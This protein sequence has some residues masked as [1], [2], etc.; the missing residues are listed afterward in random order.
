MNNFYQFDLKT[1]DNAPTGNWNAKVEVGGVT[2]NKILK[3]E[4]IKPNRLKVKLDFDEE[5]IKSGQNVNGSLNAM[6]LHGATAKA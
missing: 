1:D 2:F 6:W 4:T 3:I 5:I